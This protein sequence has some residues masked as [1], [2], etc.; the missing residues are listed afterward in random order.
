MSRVRP[1]LPAGARLHRRARR[2]HAA[3]AR[4]LPRRDA[5]L[6]VRGA[7]ARRRRAQEAAR[8]AVGGARR[9]AERGGGRLRGVSRRGGGRGPR[10]HRRLQDERGQGGQGGRRARRGLAGGRAG[11]R[12]HRGG[13]GGGGGGGG[14][15]LVRCL[16]Q[17]RVRPQRP[18]HL[19][20]RVRY[21]GL[22]ELLPSRQGARRRMVLPAVRR[23][24]ARQGAQARRVLRALLPAG[25]RARADHVRKVGAHLLLPDLR[26]GL[27]RHAARRQGR[28]ESCKALPRAQ[29]L[30]VRALSAEGRLVYPLPARKLQAGLPLVLRARQ[31]GSRRLGHLRRAAQKRPA[32]RA[33]LLR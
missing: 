20:R 21:L 10:G 2:R 30:R 11:G 1:P 18:D 15:R 29:G 33:P 3:Q 24:C 6:R 8:G 17:R 13:D 7:R 32:G 22:S 23:G 31:S 28:C 14:R 9:V 26:G 12:G 19:L 16:R 25:R 5:L 4:R 27:L